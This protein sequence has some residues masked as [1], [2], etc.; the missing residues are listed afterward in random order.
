MSKKPVDYEKSVMSELS[1]KSA[2]FPNF[3][4]ETNEPSLPPEP[5]SPAPSATPKATSTSESTQTRTPR[6]PVRPGRIE[7]SV[8]RQM[9]RHPFELY[10]DQLESLRARSELQRRN[11]QAG[12]MSQ[13]VRQAIDDYLRNNR[14][15]D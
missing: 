10:M 14:I 12:S 7:P 2:F 8:R 4:K 3:A 5:A 1:G 9:I 15:D 11:G 13:M 6:T